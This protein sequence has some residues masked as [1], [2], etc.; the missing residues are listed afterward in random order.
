MKSDID[1]WNE[2]FAGREPADRPRPDL[3]LA[4]CRHLPAGGAA[5]DVASGSGHNAVWLAHRGFDV[6]AI[7]GSVNG[8]RLAV[9]LAAPLRRRDPP[10]RGRSRPLSAGRQL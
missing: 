2:R 5:L 8:M 3:V 6:T 9:D 1:R 4:A 7:D 10:H